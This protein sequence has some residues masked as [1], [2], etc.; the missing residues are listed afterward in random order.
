MKLDKT[1][2]KF[3]VALDIIAMILVTLIPY[4]FIPILFGFTPTFDIT[5]TLTFVL[6][7]PFQIILFGLIISWR[8]IH[9]SGHIKRNIKKMGINSRSKA[10]VTLS[11]SLIFILLVVI[12]YLTID[13]PQFAFEYSN[14]PIFQKLM[15]SIVLSGTIILFPILAP[16]VILYL[17]VTMR[18]KSLDFFYRLASIILFYVFCLLS[19][20]TFTNRYHIAVILMV[21]FVLMVSLVLMKLSKKPLLT[22]GYLLEKY[23]ETILTS[24]ALAIIESKDGHSD[25]PFFQSFNELG[26]HITISQNFKPK[27]GDYVKFLG[28]KG[29][30]IGWKIDETKVI[31]FPRFFMRGSESVV[32]SMKIFFQTFANILFLKGLTTVTIDYKRKEISLQVSEDDYHVLGEATYHL[33]GEKIIINFKESVIAF[34]QEEPDKALGL[35]YP[36]PFYKSGRNSFINK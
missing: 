6:M 16:N 21:S 36:N 9:V 34:L 22:W 33:L 3:L 4:T 14:T 2:I 32:Q 29:E 17:I 18:T 7:L 28:R 23:Q 27:L 12:I 31:L 8:N 13:I 25:R 26:E 10:L 1:T 11:S 30:L 19:I 20:F 24:Q 35:L 5:Y 15:F